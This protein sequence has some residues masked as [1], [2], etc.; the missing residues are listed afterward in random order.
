MENYVFLK[1]K[2]LKNSSEAEYAVLNYDDPTVRAFAERTKANT[3]FFS[4]RER[5]N[6]AYLENG[7][8]Y[9]NGE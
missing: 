3:V 6:G 5:V 7:T 4:V 8:L 9:F 1:A 2:L